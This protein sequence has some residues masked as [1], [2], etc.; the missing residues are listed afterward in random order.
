MPLTDPAYTVPAPGPPGPFGTVGWLRATVSRFSEGETHRRRRAICEALLADL[1]PTALYEAATLQATP[2]HR[3]GAT[4]VR[5]AAAPPAPA[6][7]P[8]HS[9]EP[10]RP[11]R[12]KSLHVGGG[13]ELPYM[14]VAVLAA[15]LGVD[16][17]D[18]STAVEAVRVVAAAYH[19]GTDAP[20]ADAALARLLS[21][22]PPEDPEAAAQRIALLVQ[23]CEATAAL[24]RGA[25]TRPLEAVLA[26]DP[27]VPATRRLGPDGEVV[28]VTLAGRPF[29]AGPR[30]CPGEAHARA[31]AA[32]VVKAAR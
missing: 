25:L 4:A 11:A 5:V 6:A 12:S 27:P 10:Y 32:G 22:L 17:I 24:V 31:L 30:A 13:V 15:A 26:H 23:A 14:P 3:E 16:E 2:N 18:V 7:R 1:D 29:G 28:A 20:G 9:E 19:P 21:L 8:A